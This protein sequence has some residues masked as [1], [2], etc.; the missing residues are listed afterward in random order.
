MSFRAPRDP[1]SSSSRHEQIRSIVKVTHVYEDA[2]FK[3]NLKTSIG[4]RGSQAHMDG[5]YDYA[6]CGC[7]SLLQTHSAGVRGRF[8]EGG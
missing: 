4:I 7:Q 2:C 5:N 1:S 8:Q 3:E 6:L